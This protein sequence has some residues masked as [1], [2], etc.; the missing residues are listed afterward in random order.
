[1]ARCTDAFTCVDVDTSLE[2]SNFR[3]IRDDP[4]ES[5]FVVV[6]VVGVSDLG[7]NPSG[8]T[9]L[10]MSTMMDSPPCNKAPIRRHSL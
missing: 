7:W 1:M 6:V 8:E 10:K 9:K 2:G 5:S 3:N 4:M